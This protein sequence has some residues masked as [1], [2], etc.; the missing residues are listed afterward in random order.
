M[1]FARL[2][3]YGLTP[4]Q[5]AAMKRMKKGCWVC[6]KTRRKDGK[7]LKLFIEHDHLSGRVRGLACFRC[8]RYL[9]G[10][11]HTGR[12]LRSAADYLDSTFDG[13]DL[14]A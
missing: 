1:T 2:K 9:I 11:H 10:R 8:N 13:R 14:A 6:G 12:L 4:Y 7:L 5:F 3:K